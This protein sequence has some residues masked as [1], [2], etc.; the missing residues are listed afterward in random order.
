MTHF[1]VTLPSDS[2]TDS[3]PNNTASRFTVKLPDRIE[4]DG[5]FEVGLAEF[6][7]PHTWV[8]FDNSDGRYHI[9]I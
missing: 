5:D 8:N 4:L 9:F 6:M 1:H 3:Y 2:S 7:Y